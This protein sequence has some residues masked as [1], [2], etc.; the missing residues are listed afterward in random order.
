[1]KKRIA[2]FL[3]AAV[4]LIGVMILP[5]TAASTPFKDVKEGKWYTKPIKYVYDNKLMNGMTDTIF[6]PD[7]PMTRSMLVTVLWRVEDAPKPG[8]KTPFTDLKM[9]WYMDAVAWAYENS[10]VKGTSEKAF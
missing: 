8:G 3:L 9:K 2:S 6:E 1:M 10:I 7:S 4:M 5:T